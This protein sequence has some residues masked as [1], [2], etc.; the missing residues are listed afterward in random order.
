METPYLDG[1][2]KQ[3]EAASKKTESSNIPDYAILDATKDQDT[4]SIISVGRVTFPA[5]DLTKPNPTYTTVEK[6]DVIKGINSGKKYVTVKPS[7]GA[8]P[9]YG[10]LVHVDDNKHISTNPNASKGDNLGELALGYY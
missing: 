10:S 2:R 3:A 4:G 8:R 7:R 9:E 5:G 1:I 6:K